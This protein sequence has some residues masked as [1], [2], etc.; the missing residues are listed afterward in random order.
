ML[1][2]RS[3]HWSNRG[4]GTKILASFRGAKDCRSLSTPA[5]SSLDPKSL[6]DNTEPYRVPNLVNGEWTFTKSSISIPHPVDK[7]KNDIFT[8]PDTQIDE[9]QPFV[10]SLRKVPKTGLHNPLKNP[11]RY[12]EYGEITR[13]AGDALG[14]PDVSEHFAQ[15]IMAAIPKT[16]AQAMGEVTVTAAFLNNFAGDNVR[17]LAQSFGVP[18]DHYGMCTE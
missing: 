4:L 13:R 11:H 17:R 5:W 8:I 12:V 1:L 2:S 3:K 9:I 14:Q 18:G 10:D 16:H 7:T 6:G 15:L